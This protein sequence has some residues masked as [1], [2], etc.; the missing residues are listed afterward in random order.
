MRDVN[1]EQ[2]IILALVLLVGLVNF[3]L[4]WLKNRG[5]TPPQSRNR[6]EGLAVGEEEIDL[7]EAM[8]RARAGS[9]PDLEPARVPVQA[10][11]PDL[12]VRPADSRLPVVAPA[13]PPDFRRPSPATMPHRSPAPRPTP[14]LPLRGPPPGSSTRSAKDRR[15][16]RRIDPWEARRGVVLMTI[17]GPCRGIEPP[18]RNAS[19]ERS[20]GSV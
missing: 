16:R 15:L 4:D 20:P 13:T 12:G 1:F 17:L 7:G 10:K 19:V 6:D 3:V 2:L 11:L 8:R 5:R 18:A 9:P 14:R